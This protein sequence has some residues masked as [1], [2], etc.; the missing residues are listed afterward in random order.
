M[1]T[2]KPNT[3]YVYEKSNGIIYAREMG[4]PHSNRKIIGYDHKELEYK[5]LQEE[6]ILWREILT[7]SKT[8]PALQKAL[9]NAI[10]I[11]RLSKN[12]PL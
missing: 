5:K 10:L 9:D 2:L 8:N 1:G 7:A 3:S 6:S 12:D 11:Y 4:T